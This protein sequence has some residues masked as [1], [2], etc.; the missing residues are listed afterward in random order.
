MTR[1][2]A[3]ILAPW[4]HGAAWGTTDPVLVSV[5][6]FR[7]NR[8]RD[9]PGAYLAG[10][11]LR[12]GWRRLRGAVG[13]RLWARPWDRTSGAISVWEGEADLRRFVALAAHVKVMRT[14][15]DRAQVRSCSWTVERCVIP[16][17]ER[18]AVRRVRLL[19]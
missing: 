1:Q 14:Y 5:T 4:K 15:R 12:R 11:R 17:I 7:V 13:V 19:G 16:E 10:L 18:E 2:A 8:I 3:S 9:L 6:V